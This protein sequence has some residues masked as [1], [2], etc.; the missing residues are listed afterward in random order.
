[1]RRVTALLDPRGTRERLSVIPLGHPT[2]LKG[3]PGGENS[4]SGK[5]GCP[6]TA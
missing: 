4:M 2:Y 6:E 5:P 1:V 3:K